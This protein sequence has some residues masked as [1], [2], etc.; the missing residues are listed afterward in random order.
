MNPLLEQKLNSLKAAREFE[1][2]YLVKQPTEFTKLCYLVSV[3]K[4][5]QDN[6][7]VEVLSDYIDNEII[8]FF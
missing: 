3:L 2:W 7:S 8:F 5:Y 6:N 1:C 4:E